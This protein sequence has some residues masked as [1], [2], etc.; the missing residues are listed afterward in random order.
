MLL[1]SINLT[2]EFHKFILLKLMFIKEINLV[3]RL[4]FIQLILFQL[5]KKHI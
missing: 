1:K 3:L 5:I 4:F 2:I